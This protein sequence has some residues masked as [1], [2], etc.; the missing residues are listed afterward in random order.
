MIHIYGDSHGFFC[1]R[2]LTLPNMNHS[3]PT[4][5]MHR[6]G[7]DNII[8]NFNKDEIREKDIIILTYGEIDCRHHVNKQVNLERNEDD[9][10]HDL[11]NNYFRTIKNNLSHM[12]VIVVIV[13][14]MP[15]TKYSDYKEFFDNAEIT[16]K[17]ED[18][19]RYERK[20]NK[21]LQKMSLENN[22]IYFNPFYYY[23]RE[24]G[25]FKHEYSD[26][27]F[28]LLHNSFFL[29]KFVELYNKIN[30]PEKKKYLKYSMKKIMFS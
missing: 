13:G 22:F 10:I 23:T 19:V 24:D 14:V 11:V 15:Q 25:T 3:K 9:V 18:R 29:E 2:F 7:R 20:M 16:G 28:H 8:V 4:I 27:T 1:F 26:K 6:I 30:K 17:D 21:I 12:N 5:T